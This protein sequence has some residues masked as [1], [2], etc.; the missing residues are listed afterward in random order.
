[1]ALA[2]SFMDDAGNGLGLRIKQARDTLNL[3]QHDLAKKIGITRAAVGQW[4]IGTT[5]PSIEKCESVAKALKVDPAWLA[6]GVV[7]GAVRTVYESPDKEKITW[8]PHVSLETNEVIG[9]KW[10]FP[11]AFIRSIRSSEES[12]IMTDVT[13]SSIE[14]IF[15]RGSRVLV[16]TADTRPSP[17]GYF[18]IN[19][20]VGV[21]FA[22]LQVVPK[23]GT[24]EV[25]IT[26]R[27]QEA[28]V[29][30]LDAIRIIGRITG[31]V[32]GN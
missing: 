1:M 27:G 13:S 28:M 26:A 15:P 6:Y 2:V 11:T 12:T 22:H 21:G 7:S 32:H 18:V 20:G 24:P 23:Q 9:E 4:E 30:E 8:V 17:A 29:V 25:R 10:G 31:S 16:D 3:T 19:D 14:P 5:S